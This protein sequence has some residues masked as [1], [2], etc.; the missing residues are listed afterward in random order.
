MQKSTS[1]RRPKEFLHQAYLC[2][3]LY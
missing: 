2:K 1:D 3:S